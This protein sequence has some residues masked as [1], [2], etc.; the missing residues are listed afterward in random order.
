MGAALAGAVALAGPA[1]AQS[2]VSTGQS[3]LEANLLAGRMADGARIAGLRMR[4]AP[5]WKT[6]WRSPGEAGVPP[7]FD[8]AGSENL[9]SIEVLWPRPEIFESFG[10]RTVGYSDEVV[11]PIRLVPENA[12]APIRLALEMQAGVC[13]EICVFEQVSLSLVAA[14][15]EASDVAPVL[16]AL[17]AVPPQG[18]EAEIS[19]AHCRIEGAGRE[20]RLAAE[21]ALADTA[22]QPTVLIEGPPEAWV[23]DVAVDGQNERLAITATLAVE[24][25]AWI[26]RGDIRLTLLGDSY[27]ADIAGCVAG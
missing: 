18:A 12:A 23:Y 4:L 2:L 17:A 5:G 22:G 10:I 26:D 19:V 3:F 1:G 21:I 20:R 7:T 9:R 8:W 24:E 14:P 15:G 6:Y 11:L 27:A 13:R 25:G 16:A